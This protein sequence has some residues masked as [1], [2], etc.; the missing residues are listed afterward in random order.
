MQRRAVRLAVQ[1]QVQE[2]SSPQFTWCTALLLT[3]SSDPPLICR[4]F[5]LSDD[6]YAQDSMELLKQSG[7]DFVQNEKR[8]ID[9]SQFGELLMTSG[10]VLN[11]E[12]LLSIRKN[13]VS[14]DPLRCSTP[15]Q[16]A[17][18]TSCWLCSALDI[19]P[20][21]FAGLPSIVDMT[22]ATCLKY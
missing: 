18:H 22:L 11:D 1:F 8:G 17:P 10:I 5:K 6:M 15:H 16:T 13:T 4:E 9:V 3:C 7:I 12:V 21:R 14:L 2:R 19:L 20:C